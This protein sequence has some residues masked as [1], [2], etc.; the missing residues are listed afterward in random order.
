MFF[1]KIIT[2]N[3]NEVICINNDYKMLGYEIYLNN[4]FF[5]IIY[6]GTKY[7]IKIIYLNNDY[8]WYLKPY[9][10]SIFQT[11]VKNN[12]HTLD[13]VLFAISDDQIIRQNN[14]T[15]KS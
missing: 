15:N 10:N 9:N 13:L 14:E 2:E 5:E 6:K 1:Q 8:Y 7:I 11:Q 12:I 3:I 4:D